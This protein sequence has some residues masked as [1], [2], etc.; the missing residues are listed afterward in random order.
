MIVSRPARVLAIAL[1]ATGTLALDAAWAQQ[2]TRPFRGLFGAGRPPDQNRMRHEVTAVVNGLAGYDDNLNPGSLQSGVPLGGSAI[3]NA[4]LATRPSGY[5][6]SADVEVRYSASKTTRSFN[7]TGRTFAS[8]FQNMSGPPI[9]GSEL[10]ASQRVRIGRR[11]DVSF[12][13]TAQR[14]PYFTASFLGPIQATAGVVSQQPTLVN[15]ATLGTST[16]LG[17]SAAFERE[18]TRRT[19]TSVQYGYTR[20]AHQDPRVFKNSSHGGTVTLTRTVGRR[21]HNLHASYGR[22]DYDL[23]HTG[24]FSS[25]VTNSFQGGGSYQ[26]QLGRRRSV[27]IT[28]GG[29]MQHV[30]RYDTVVYDY[31]LPTSYANGVIGIGRSWSA[32]ATYR[33]SL[34]VLPAPVFTNNSFLS[35]AL[36]VGAGGYIGSRLDLTFNVGLSNG[37]VSGF[38]SSA[39]ATNPG[40]YR[41][42]TSVAQARVQLNRFW[43]AVVVFNR[44]DGRINGIPLSQQP[45]SVAIP[46]NTNRNAVSVGFSWGIP[47]FGYFDSS[48]PMVGSGR[49]RP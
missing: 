21:D 45:L 3:S 26:K 10:N 5:L 2:P 31:W 19:S 6:G 34:N 11:N 20:R 30:K 47:L 41:G 15:A 43:S 16:T 37:T 18:W 25:I 17:T 36:A 40:S 35:H 8:A 1:L 48:N 7:V 27:A 44:Y 24:I 46:T 49:N 42:Y 38:A 13:E 22:N 29:G 12:T 14:M 32:N 39:N 9:S 28:G 33:Q 4:P 23:S